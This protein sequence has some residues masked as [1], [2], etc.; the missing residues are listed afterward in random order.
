MNLEEL[1]QKAL[2]ETEI[3]R[4]PIKRLITFGT[5]NCDYIFL[6]PSVVNQGDTVVRKG[7][8]DIAPPAIHVPKHKPAF[9]GFDEPDK[10][11]IT[12]DQLASFFY[13]RGISFPSLSYKNEPYEL[14]LFEGS[15]AKAEKI[16]VDMVRTHEKISTGIVIGADSAWQ[17]SVILMAC[18]L[19]DTYVD[20]DLKLILDR[21]KKK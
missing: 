2:Q 7:K 4:L 1:W 12:D 9:E 5:T 17:F 6:A 14:D 21:I 8:L 3:V 20:N 13:L 19:I 15:V 10:D 11:G 16:F 18:H